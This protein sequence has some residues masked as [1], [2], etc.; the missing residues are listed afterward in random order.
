M[1]NKFK[2]YFDPKK[3]PVYVGTIVSIVLVALD[4]VIITQFVNLKPPLGNLIAL[5]VCCV[6]IS[7][8]CFADLYWVKNIKARITLYCIDFALL[9]V[10]CTLSGNSYLS[11]LYCVI[12]S[13]FYV[14]IDGFK[15]KLA[16]F[17][18]SCVTFVVSFVIG[19]V[20]NH[21]GAPIYDSALEILSGCLWGISIISVHFFVA[22]FLIHYYRTTVRL[23]EALAEADKSKTELKEAYEQLA[24][25]AVFEERN[26]IAR[27][28][29]DNAGHSMTAVIMQTEAAKL[30]IENN[31]EEAKARLI[32]ANMQAK[33]ALEQMRESVHLL[34]GRGMSRSLKQEIEAVIAQTMDGTEVKIRSDIGDF[35]L[36]GERSR[37]LTNSLKEC[38]ANG[39]RH[40]GATAFYIEL[41]EEDGDVVL[42]VSDNGSGLPDDFKEGF[43][44]KGIREKAQAFGGTIYCE[45]E[46]GDG[47]EM[48]VRIP[49][50]NKENK[51]EKL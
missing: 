7:I 29:H 13:Q 50:V 6:L 31:P 32:S 33:N 47:V 48:T 15:P 16:V 4:V 27:D 30:L 10:I 26:R 46:S 23:T 22:L 21:I 49:A 9:L 44:I 3:L 34:A 28:I 39:L 25:T 2:P 43:G 36:D 12:L 20:M 19:W 17:I 42:T 24:E 1:D 5:I 38:I 11:A 14:N 45:S 51:G 41:K 37:F 40:G 35:E 8:L 18:T